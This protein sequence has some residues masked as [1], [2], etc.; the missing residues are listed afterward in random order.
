M[1]K[2]LSANSQKLSNHNKW[3]VQQF[4]QSRR[5]A[6]RSHVIFPQIR[7]QQSSE[8]EGTDSEFVSGEWPV[9]WSLVSM[10]DCNA[11]YIEKSLKSDLEAHF[12]LADI[13]D[14]DY[15]TVTESTP[16]AQ[17]EKMVKDTG[18]APVI[19]TSGLLLGMIYEKDLKKSGSTASDIMEKPIAATKEN[20]AAEGACIMLKHRISN[21]PIVDE[22]AVLIGMVNSVEIFQ[23]MEIEAGMEAKAVEF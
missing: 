22:K 8:S 12:K 9:N 13:M 3:N 5:S 10:E 17:L 23:A 21:L 11:Y 7:A 1:Y 4:S 16:V 15:G 2:C 6:K 18:C 14:T 19:S 20:T